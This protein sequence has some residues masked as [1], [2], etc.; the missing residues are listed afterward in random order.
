MAASSFTVGGTTYP[1]TVLASDPPKS[2]TVNVSERHIPGGP[3]NY[4]DIGGP[5]LPHLVLTLKFNTDAAFIAFENAYGQLGTLVNFDGHKYQAIPTNPR[6]VTHGV[7]N[8]V[9]EVAV[10]FLLVRTLA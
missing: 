10:D 4:I 2:T 6:R 9:N 7:L 5:S 3:Y 8:Q 1:L